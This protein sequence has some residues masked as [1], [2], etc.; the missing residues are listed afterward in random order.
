MLN[1]V[2]LTGNL[3]DDPSSHYTPEGLRNHNG[4]MLSDVFRVKLIVQ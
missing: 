2:I 3:G 1:Q 4:C